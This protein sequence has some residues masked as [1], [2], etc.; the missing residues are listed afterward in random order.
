MPLETLLVELGL[1]EKKAKLYLALLQLGTANVALI[2][3]KAQVKRPTAYVLLEEM[4]TEQLVTEL[5]TARDRYFSPLKPELLRE[6]LVT[7]LNQLETALPQLNNLISHQAG[8]PQV[9]VREGKAAI[10]EEYYLA[11][12]SGEE[13]CFITDIDTLSSDFTDFLHEY[14]SQVKKQQ[15]QVRELV[16]NTFVGRKYV[17]EAKADAPYRQTRV[18]HRTVA[19]DN[20]IYGDT[21]LIVSFKENN[22]FLVKITNPQIAL[23]YKTNF[24]QLWTTSSAVRTSKSNRDD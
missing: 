8:R 12:N 4:L 14:N 13:V 17:R 7:K 19:N 15:K 20:V 16:S 10:I 18:L 22:Y 3:E 23:T 6:R 5:A 24:E 9:E 2:A 11:L 1:S 21:L